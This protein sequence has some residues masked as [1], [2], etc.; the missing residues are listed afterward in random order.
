LSTAMHAGRLDPKDVQRS[1]AN[2]LQVIFNSA[3]VDGF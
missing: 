1:A 2:V 3:V